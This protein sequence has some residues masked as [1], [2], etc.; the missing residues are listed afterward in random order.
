MP[1]CHSLL[2]SPGIST[3]PCSSSKEACA[4]GP[5]NRES[6]WLINPFPKYKENGKEILTLVS[7]R[8]D[9]GGAAHW[10]CRLRL[11]PLLS[12]DDY[13]VF[14]CFGKTE[15]NAKKWSWL[16]C[17]SPEYFRI[18]KKISKIINMINYCCYFHHHQHHWRVYQ[19]KRLTFHICDIWLGSKRFLA[20]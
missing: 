15:L 9:G 3:G 7:L 11:A 1:W 8:L 4:E 20:S 10:H 5:W 13:H 2:E 16:L 19:S 12:P 18:S 17:C 14:W 6:H